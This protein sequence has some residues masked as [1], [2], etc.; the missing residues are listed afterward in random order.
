MKQN[1]LRSKAAWVIIAAVVGGVVKRY[2]PGITDDWQ[3]VTDAIITVLT[4]FGVFN[5]PTNKKGF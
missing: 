4:V 3:L 5:D 1:R 2:I